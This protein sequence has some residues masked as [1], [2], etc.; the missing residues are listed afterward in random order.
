[1]RLG[2]ALLLC[3]ACVRPLPPP[4]PL[5][6]AAD[7]AMLTVPAGPYVAG[8]T[9]DEREIAYRLAGEGARRGRMFEREE[10]RQAAALPAFR[11]DRTH[12]TNTM[13]A[14]WLRAT[15]GR[16]P[17]IDEAGW[18]RQGFRQDYGREVMRSLWHGQT[19]PTGRG[20]HPV[21]LVTHAEATAYCRWRGLRLPSAAEL[22]KAMRGPEGR[23]YPWGDEWDPTRLNGAPVWDTEPVGRYPTGAGPFGHLDLAGLAFQWTSTPAPWDSEKALVKGS[24]WDDGPA[25]GRG[26][27]RH[28]RPRAARHILVGFRCAGP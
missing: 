9:P 18:R 8:S 2:L 13:F 17:T 19:P 23:T 22:E 6:R 1:V 7:Q 10:P 15:G 16:G 28:G 25:I 11:L 21:V 12:V 20:D 4:G 5:A 3:A 27:Q 24:A 26:A 14:E